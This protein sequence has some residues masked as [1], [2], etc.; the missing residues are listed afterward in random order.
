MIKRIESIMNKNNSE[1]TVSQDKEDESEW[2]ALANV[3]PAS[4]RPYLGVR[5]LEDIKTIETSVKGPTEFPDNFNW[6]HFLYDNK[7]MSILTD[8]LNQADCGSCYAMA[9]IK[10]VEA[11]LNYLH[12]NNIERGEPFFKL[13]L[14]ETLNCN[15]LN[16]ACAGG[17]PYSLSKV[18]NEIGL[19]SDSC[20]KSISN[21]F[22]KTTT[23]DKLHGNQWKPIPPGSFADSQ[24]G[25]VSGKLSKECKKHLWA[26][27][28]NYVGGVYGRSNALLLQK[29]LYEGGPLVVSLEPDSSFMTYQT[30][31]IGHSAQQNNQLK[32]LR[33]VATHSHL[34]KKTTTNRNVIGSMKQNQSV[35]TILK[36]FSA[37]LAIK[38]TVSHS[39]LL[40]GWGQTEIN[41]E[42][43]KY[44]VLQNSWGETWGEKGMFL[45]RRGNDH[46]SIESIGVAVDPE[47]REEGIKIE[48]SMLDRSKMEGIDVFDL[49]SKMGVSIPWRFVL[50]KTP[51]W[52]ENNSHDNFRIKKGD[53][54]K[55]NGK[56]RRIAVP[57]Q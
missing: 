36:M 26:K 57:T 53:K 49:R 41:G 13:S 54:A 48:T 2:T 40:T 44:W 11:R 32:S 15:F 16:Q 1:S 28:F 8:V 33:A 10:M 21:P 52:T 29:T 18:A 42:T 22:D 20:V 38:E 9:W 56:K 24:P 17:F 25:P 23:C 5:I 3:L 6:A 55:K 45:M 34:A 14:D 43:V 27:E 19:H 50:N 46:L 39:V 12:F 37:K 31:I 30:G 51:D 7:P 47:I 4:T 35:K